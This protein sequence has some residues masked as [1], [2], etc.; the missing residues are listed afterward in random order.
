MATSQQRLYDVLMERVSTDRY[1]S[2]QLL[3]RIEQTLYTPEQVVG[4]VDM[5]I[6][7]IDES[8]YPSGQLLDRVQRMLTVAAAAAELRELQESRRPNRIGE[9]GALASGVSQRPRYSTTL[10]SPPV[11]A[12]LPGRPPCG[13]R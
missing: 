2:H 3:D 5:L 9:R 12:K 4:Y 10:R 8:W 11:P 13:S 1:P 6:E 7:K